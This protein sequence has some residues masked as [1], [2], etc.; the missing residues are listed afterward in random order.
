LLN[1]FT[2][3]FIAMKALDDIIK[4]KEVSQ[5][6]LL[7]LP[8]VT[9]IDVGYKY[10]GGQRTDEVSIRVMV[11]KK[12]K[13]VPVKQRIP[14]KIKGIKTDVIQR[15]FEPLTLRKPVADATPVPDNKKYDPLQGGISIGPDREINGYVYAGTLGC[16]VTDKATGEPRLLSNFHVMAVDD[17]WKAG[18]AMVQPSKVDGGTDADQIG[19]LAKAVLSNHVDGAL[20]TVEGRGTDCAIVDIGKV[21]GTAT[22]ALNAAV[23]KRGRTTLLTYGFVDAVNG[24]VKI[25]YGDGIGAK[26]LTDQ[27]GIRPDTAHNDKFSDHGDSG[28]AVV[29]ADNNVIGL[30]FAGSPDG[31]TYIN[32]IANVLSELDIE[33]CTKAK[34]RKKIPKKKAKVKHHPSP[35]KKTPADRS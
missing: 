14:A 27:I 30:L 18:D 12:K 33:V 10:V 23:R 29:D 5:A 28:S 8:G 22:A 21:K 13:T 35:K 11:T 15:I 9:G 34:T 32:L 3:K 4:Q 16:I 24:T 25:D 17:S 1:S 20:S 7:K 19:T 26:T 6:S 2:V 31:Y